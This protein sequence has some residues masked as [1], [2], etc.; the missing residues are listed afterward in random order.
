MHA[1]QGASRANGPWAPGPPKISPGSPQGPRTP[2]QNIGQAKLKRLAK[3]HQIL[4]G[5]GNFSGY[6][7]V[8]DRGRAAAAAA[9]A[10]EA[11]AD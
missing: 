11:A 6:V 10:P 9:A 7:N 4:S 3:Y 2:W 8:F 5:F 1:G